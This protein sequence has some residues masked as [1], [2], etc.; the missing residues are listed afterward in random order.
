MPLDFEDRASDSLYIDRLWRCRST[1][2]DEMTSI[3]TAHWTLV[4]WESAGAVGVAVQGPETRATRAPVPPDGS[5]VGIRFALGVALSGLPVGRLVDGY[6]ELGDASR[7]SVWLKGSHWPLFDYGSAEDFV[8][9]LVAAGVL[10]RDPFVARGLAGQSMDLSAHTVRRRFQRSTGLTA[11]TIGRIERSRHAA[12][13]VRHQRPLAEVT[14]EL[15]YY[16]HP[17]L[18]RS[19]T[20]F[21]G[22]PA[23]WLRTSPPGQL[24]FLY[25]P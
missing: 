21:I 5:F 20:R 4:R 9:A 15:G 18:A 3:A 25:K 11:Q 24:S 19:L 22:H 14:H 12:W 17:H 10:T 7:R 6:L 1:D 23:S 16:D 8:A 13:L 2:I